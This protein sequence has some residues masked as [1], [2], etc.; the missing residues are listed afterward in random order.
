MTM[1]SL[2]YREFQGLNEIIYKTSLVS[3]FLSLT[4]LAWNELQS[5]LRSTL[6]NTETRSEIIFTQ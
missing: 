2:A 4:F 1:L 3:R 5:N 6:V